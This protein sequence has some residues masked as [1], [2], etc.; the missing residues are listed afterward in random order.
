MNHNKFYQEKSALL[1][2]LAAQITSCRY[3]LEAIG[4]LTPPPNQPDDAKH[5]SDLTA[6]LLRLTEELR[7]VTDAMV[8]P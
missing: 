3:T 1:T 4:R 7:D 8:V 2:A 6:D 5:L